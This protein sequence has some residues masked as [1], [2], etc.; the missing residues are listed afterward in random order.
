MNG[1]LSSSLKSFQS[2]VYFE[3]QATVEE[4]EKKAKQETKGDALDRV[5]KAKEAK[6]R[7]TLARRDACLQTKEFGISL[8]VSKSF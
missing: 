1:A 2:M 4:L 6:E 5:I 3:K 7:C 8:E